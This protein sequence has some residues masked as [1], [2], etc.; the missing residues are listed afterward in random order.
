MKFVGAI[1]SLEDHCVR[2]K[3]IVCSVNDLLTAGVPS[4]F[5]RTEKLARDPRQDANYEYRITGAGDHFE[6]SAIPRHSGLGGFYDDG[7]AVHFNPSGP[8]QKQDKVFQGRIEHT[9]Y[10][11]F[12]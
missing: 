8:A 6:L 4:V 9:G 2:Q 1:H 11:N 10:S 3:K 5:G 7:T 12:N